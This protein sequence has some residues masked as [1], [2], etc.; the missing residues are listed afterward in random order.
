MRLGAAIQQTYRGVQKPEYFNVSD[1]WKS[2]V[3][4]VRPVFDFIPQSQE[5]T[6][7]VRVISS[8]LLC[9]CV[10]RSVGRMGD[11][12]AVFLYVP[13]AAEIGAAELSRIYQSFEAICRAD[14]LDIDSLR[15]MTEVEYREKKSMEYTPSKREA[16]RMAVFDNSCGDLGKFLSLIGYQQFNSEY[17]GVIIADGQEESINTED[18]SSKQLERPITIMPPTQ[19]EM[20]RKW[21]VGGVTLYVND[22]PFTAPMEV[23][24]GSTL[25]VE[26]RRQH[27]NPVKFTVRPIIDGQS[28]SVNSAQPFT[29]EISSRNFTVLDENGSPIKGAEISINSRLL[30]NFRVSVNAAD[31]ARLCVRAGGYETQELEFLPLDITEETIYLKRKVLEYKG[32]IELR[33]GV[34][35]DIILKGTNLPDAT[36]APELYGYRMRRTISGVEYTPDIAAGIDN[37]KKKAP[38]LLFVVLSLLLFGAGVGLTLL[39]QHIFPAAGDGPSEPQ[40]TSALDYVNQNV[41][42]RNQME[43]IPELQGLFDA[44]VEYDS[45]AIC[46]PELISMQA[47]SERLRRIIE[48]IQKNPYPKTINPN[49]AVNGDTINADRYVDFLKAPHNRGTRPSTTEMIVAEPVNTSAPVE[50]DEDVQ[51]STNNKIRYLNE[52]EEWSESEMRHIGL[53]VKI[54]N[55]LNS[56][57]IHDFL[58]NLDTIVPENQRSPNLRNLVSRLQPYKNRNYHA[59]RY[60][61][62]GTLLPYSDEYMNWLG[63]VAA[64]EARSRN[65]PDSDNVDYQDDMGADLP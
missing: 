8:G 62:T 59:S 3:G 2:S 29:R 39:Y 54:Y 44:M 40:I 30:S 32:I 11:N 65:N 27:C 31:K 26:A 41:F 25:E 42:V 17:K 51:P 53:W 20:E 61:T 64:D 49:T 46:K 33:G 23:L 22:R 55:A 63:G 24:S 45:A 36:I 16:T 34:R 37:T 9:C 10:T 5:T 1:D 43:Q 47:G 15:R 58:T 60:S 50:G 12:D 18:I 57:N 56:G 21:N 13:A 28:I 14:R 19:E 52:N 6:A 4:D 38:V 35:A 7:F 48:A